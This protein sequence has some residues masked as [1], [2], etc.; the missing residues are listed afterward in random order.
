MIAAGGRSVAHAVPAHKC[1]QESRHDTRNPGG[2]I[3]TRWQNP[4]SVASFASGSLWKGVFVH[5]VRF[6]VGD[7][8]TGK[9]LAGGPFDTFEA[10]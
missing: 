1:Q 5:G 6:D 7:D 3:R 4:L 8:V 10:G 2:L 9:I